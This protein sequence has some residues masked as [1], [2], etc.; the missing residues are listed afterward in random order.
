MKLRRGFVLSRY[1]FVALPFL[2]VC[3]SHV[4]WREFLSDVETVA[5]GG[6]LPHARLFVIP[7]PPLINPEGARNS[8]FA[9]A[10]DLHSMGFADLF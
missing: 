1:K 6:D 2:N 10:S 8:Y 5:S 7:H 9:M 4:S 3:V